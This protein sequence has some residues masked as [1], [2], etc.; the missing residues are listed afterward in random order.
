M[1]TS[2]SNKSQVKPEAVREQILH[3]MIASFKIEG[4]HIPA[5]KALAT[6]RKVELNLEK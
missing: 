4:I 1:S 6:L 3:S 5:D 2:K